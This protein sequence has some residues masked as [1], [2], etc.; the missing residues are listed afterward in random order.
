MEKEKEKGEGKE[1][2]MATVRS[3]ELS[4]TFLLRFGDG[5]SVLSIEQYKVRVRERERSSDVRTVHSFQF[6]FFQ[7]GRE[8]FPDHTACSVPV[9]YRIVSYRMCDISESELG[10]G[11]VTPA[12]VT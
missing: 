12:L 5:L 2:A 8:T 9:S 4:T 3:F 1:T 10:E 11:R 6:S 7:I